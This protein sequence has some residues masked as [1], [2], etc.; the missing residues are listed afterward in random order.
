MTLY[1]EWL[2]A[3][4]AEAKA[5]EK[6]RELEDRITAELAITLD[7]E[8]VRRYADAGYDVKVTGRM[9]R[10]VDSEQL[11]EIAIENGLQ[12]YLRTLFKWKPEL[13]LSA[14]KATDR[15]ITDV[16]ARAVTTTPGRPSFQIE[17]LKD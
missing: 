2:K 9:N 8:G 1:Q 10:K 7:F 12:E 4:K 3:K 6:R 13:S 11:Q 15:S 5:T 17:K 14:W 16:L